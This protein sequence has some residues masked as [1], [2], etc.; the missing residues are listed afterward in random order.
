MFAPIKL[1]CADHAGG[2]KLRLIQWDGKKWNAIS[3][4]LSG[5]NDFSKPLVLSSAETLAKEM[6][7]A[8]RDCSAGN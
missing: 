5:T 6:G 3:D 8:P 1:S 4:W 7:R 2:G